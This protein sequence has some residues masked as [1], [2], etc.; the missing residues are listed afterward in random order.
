MRGCIAVVAMTCDPAGFAAEHSF[1]NARYG[2]PARL[3]ASWSYS[4]ATVDE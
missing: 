1:N 2:S 3:E 4:R